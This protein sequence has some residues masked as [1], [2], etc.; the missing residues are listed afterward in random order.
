[1]S[2]ELWR[3]CAAFFVAGLALAGAFWFFRA[4]VR[5]EEGKDV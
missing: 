5:T 4:A 1:M 2:L 3:Y